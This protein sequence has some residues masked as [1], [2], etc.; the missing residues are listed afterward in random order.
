MSKSSV[1]TNH[2][3]AYC[4]DKSLISLIEECKALTTEQVQLLFFPSLRTTQRR[5]KRL[6]EYKT[7]KRGRERLGEPYYY[8]LDK[9]PGQLEHVLG[10]NWIYIWLRKHVRSWERFH[11]FDWEPDYGL[12]RPDGFASI[13]NLGTSEFRH[14]FVE[15]DVSDSR[16]PFDKKVKKYNEFYRNGKYKSLWWSECATGFPSI[17]TVTTGNPDKLREKINRENFAGLNFI[18][19]S[20]EDIREACFHGEIHG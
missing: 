10:V 6:L 2:Q 15:F 9:R 17:I 16:H 18:T 5:L 8:Y 13:K 12:I 14:H 1:L 11:A 19:Y 7:L 4:R 3:L 20:I